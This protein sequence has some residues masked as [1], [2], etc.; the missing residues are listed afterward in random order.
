MLT[1]ASN[2]SLTLF[3]I[4]ALMCY[5]CSYRHSPSLSLTPLRL[6]GTS[7][8]N[9]LPSPPIDKSHRWS[10]CQ[11]E[12]SISPVRI[13]CNSR[14]CSSGLDLNFVFLPYGPWWRRHRRAFVQQFPT[15]VRPEH[16]HV[17][18]E[19]TVLFLRK[20]LTDPTDLC[21]HIR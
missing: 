14:V 7:W 19:T 6:P 5:A 17:Q 18:R 1:I 20:L 4:Q 21:E 13:S 12:I 10:L 15:P 2:S 3:A 16:L 8:R 11:C 9:D